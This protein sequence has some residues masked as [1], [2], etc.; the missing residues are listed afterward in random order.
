[1]RK[2]QKPKYKKVINSLL[3][4]TFVTI[5]S[6]SKSSEDFTDIVIQETTKDSD[7]DGV[8]DSVEE[9]NG[10]DPLKAD[11]DGD[12]VNDGVEKTDGTDPLKADSD[13]DGVDD[14]DEK[15]N[16]SD[17]LK[18]DSDSDGVDDGDE[19]ANGTDPLKADSDDDGISDSAEKTDGTNP[20]KSDS[21][22][23]GVIDG[24]EKSDKTDA[25]DNCSFL[26]NS[27]TTTTSEAWN[28]GNC[29]SDSF[30]NIEEIKNG[31]NP[32]VFNEET[33]EPTEEPTEEPIAL[34]IGT[35]LLTSAIINNGIATTTVS[36]MDLEIP[37]TSTSENENAQITLSGSP[38]KIV[39]TGTYKTILKYT[40]LGKNHEEVIPLTSPL[41]SGSWK[42]VDSELIVDANKVTNGNY[43]I[44]ELTK[45]TLKLE[46]EVN[47][48]VTAG[49]ADLN[50]KG[51]LVITFKRK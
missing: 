8:S 44:L 13:N 22:G 28:A 41:E 6:C 38:N 48:V 20:L 18:T 42:I 14:G 29:D 7:D 47:R 1:M 51:T 37:F 27:Q 46:T 2:L 12:G 9:T 31:T 30:T 23:D 49:G 32:L 33:T 5:I 34:E 15:A 19:K 10:T 35:W 26:K 45:T 43:K 11:S 17:P 36:D 3:L 40:V 4:L 50:T 25:L 24:T 21:D 16:G 39:S